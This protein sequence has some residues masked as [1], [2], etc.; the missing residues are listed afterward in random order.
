MART[1]AR[2]ASVP[3]M[4]YAAAT[5]KPRLFGVFTFVVVTVEM[6]SSLGDVGLTRYG[7]RT[8]VR[9][10]FERERLASIMLTIQLITSTVLMA[11]AYTAVLIISPE[12]PKKEVILIGLVA[13]FFS[14][15]IYTTETIL[16][17]T[18]KFGASAVLQVVG[19]LIYL[20]IGFS[21]L[22]L[23]Y[24]V[25]AVMAALVVSMGIESLARM[26]YTWKKVT[27]FS[28]DFT[29]AEFMKITRG[30]MPFALTGLATLIY[31]RADTIIL[32]VL[33][34][35]ADVGIYGAAYSFFS[36]FVWV[37]IVLSRTILP[38]VTERHKK[39]AEDGNRTSWFWYRAS[40]IAG[41]VMAYS[42]TVMAGPV[43]RTLMPSDYNES[44]ITLQL[45]IWSIPF[46]MMISIGFIALT[47]NDKEMAG[48]RTTISSALIIIAL[49]FT[50]IPAFGVKGA[51][52]AMIIATGLWFAQM[53][54][55]LSRQVF[56]ADHGVRR[57][58]SMPLLGLALM[59]GVGFALAPLGEIVTLPA[60]LIVFVSV[61]YAGWH[62]EG[63]KKGFFEDE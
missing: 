16:T 7:T 5:L 45:L 52:A 58:F 9:G 36:F 44:I 11:V 1:F 42:M 4:L 33:R 3:F 31:Y 55:I 26:V 8:M 29:A 39:D 22:L 56:S 24:S 40:C 2:L 30:T 60:G 62:F 19:K 17:G 37:P 51:A 18:K 35:D 13:I 34:G 12:S 46:L 49:D 23:G 14:S 50:L 20:F 41:I 38:S 61:I 63:L 54:W 32:E 43:I 53:Q 28:R 25:V 15:F 57:T 27:G 48:A 10:E 21:V 59:A 6:L 47:V